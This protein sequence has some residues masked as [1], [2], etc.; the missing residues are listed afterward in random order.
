DILKS[1]TRRDDLLLTKEEQEASYRV[2]RISGNQ[3]QEEAVEQ[4]LDLFLHT[5]NNA[6]FCQMVQKMRL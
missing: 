1:G 6:A 4:V 5:P 2:H 3:K